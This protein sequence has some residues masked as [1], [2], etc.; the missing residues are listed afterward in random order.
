MLPP[1]LINDIIERAFREDIGAGDLTTLYTVPA[2]KSGCGNL[3]A[4]E[5]GLIAGIDAAVSAF[6]YLDGYVDCE[7]L[8]KDGDP[9][10][11]G[12]LIMKVSGPLQ[13]ILSSERIA[14]NFLQ[15]LSGIAT[16]TAEWVE[17]IKEYPTRLTDTRKTTPGLRLLEKH[18]VFIGGGFN[19]RLALDGGILI[20]DNHIIAAGSII[21]AVR[22][23]RNMA[24]FTLR[25]EVEVSNLDELDEAIAAKA[26]IIML[27]NM[28]T[29]QICQAV[30]LTA[31]RALLEA[32]GNIT[33]QRLKEIADTGVDL[34][35]CG[36]LTHSSRSLDFSFNLNE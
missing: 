32:S 11:A 27:D 24:P 18:A 31:G 10:D 30:K 4:K 21:N 3:L 20:K 6:R 9:V 17:E 28:E 23:V 5:T 34:I 36:A 7:C 33:R 29:S 26:D 19:H 12:S 1:Y 16:Q 22:A 15:R 2:G 13:A 25:I 35:S 8:L 14:L